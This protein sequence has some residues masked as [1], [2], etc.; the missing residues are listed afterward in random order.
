V[1]ISGEAGTDRLRNLGRLDVSATAELT[2]VEI[3]V[4]PNSFSLPEAVMPEDDI[5]SGV[6]A[7]ARGLVGG[8]GAD[9]LLNEGQMTLSAETDFLTV[10]IAITD[11]VIDGSSIDVLIDPP[12]P[13]ERPEDGSI[14]EIVG[15]SGDAGRGKAGDDIIGNSGS[16]S[17]S[18]KSV[19]QTAAV[20]VAVPINSMTGQSETGLGK[21]L[22]MVSLGL[23]EGASSAALSFATGLDG[24][25]GADRIDHSGSL[26]LVSTAEA[27]TLSISVDVLGFVSGG[28]EEGEDSGF[29][30]SLGLDIY[31]TATFAYAGTTGISGGLGDDQLTTT[32]ASTNLVSADA[33]ARN[34]DVNVGFTTEEKSISVAGSAVYAR[35]WSGAEATGI[36]GGG[37]ADGIDSDGA[38]IAS[39]NALSQSCLLYTSPSPRDH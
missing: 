23:S 35:L 15:I 37:G 20:S 32:A 28:G 14:A 1:G 21:L 19:V 7:L 27:D 30:V 29:N 13:P 11:L 17:G 31:N 24:G 3:S 6:S 39:A 33:R 36:S 4:T 12:G 26:A 16:I 34:L 25:G 5:E 9:T 22:D 8:G 2:G 18:A 10:S 38:I